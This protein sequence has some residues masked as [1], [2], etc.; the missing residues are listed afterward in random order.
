[1]IDNLDKMSELKYVSICLLLSALAS[2]FA[3]LIANSES[4]DDVKSVYSYSRR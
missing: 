4:G 1:M 2:T 3:Y